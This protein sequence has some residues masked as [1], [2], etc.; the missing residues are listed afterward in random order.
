MSF[1]LAMR[2]N[3]PLV[4]ELIQ[5]ICAASPDSIV[6]ETISRFGPDP[7]ADPGSIDEDAFWTAT[8]LAA[9]HHVNNQAHNFMGF[10]SHAMIGAVDARKLAHGQP[11]P[12]RRLLLLQSLVQVVA[13]MHDLYLSPYQLL[14]ARPFQEAS[15]PESI[16]CLRR[17]VRIGEYLAVDHRLVGLRDA[18]PTADLVDLILDIGLEGIVTDDHTLISPVLSLSIIDDL[19][20]WQRGFD[21][22]RWAPRYSASFQVDV[23]SYERSLALRDEFD[24]RAGPRASHFQPE[25][26]L[27]LSERLLAASPADRPRL[28]ARALAEDCCAPATVAAAAA[29]AACTMYLMVEPVP[30][31]DYDAVSREVAPIH[32]GNSLRMLQEGLAYMQPPTQVLAALQAGSLLE[33]GPSVIDREFRFVP[34]TPGRAFPF[35]ED[36]AALTGRSPTYILDALD[37]ALPAHDYRTATAAVHAYAALDAPPTALIDRLV[38]AACTDNGTILHNFKHLNSMITQF[39]RSQLPDRWDFLAQAAR[40]IAWYCGVSTDVYRR[41]VAVQPQW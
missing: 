17:D 22:L 7:S 6:N 25:R 30:H 21:L 2:T 18:L 38:A 39:Y 27:P 40:F 41:A 33:R 28:V 12:I 14:P 1:Q 26:I 31:S 35:P 37:A 32:I 20:G 34:F 11:A 9:T 36:V 13:D 4:L 15:V 24:L 29:R 19:I 3:E 10:V 23:G 16:R 8:V 5:W